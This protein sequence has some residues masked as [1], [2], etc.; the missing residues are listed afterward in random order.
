MGDK[1]KITGIYCIENIIDGKKYIG[2]GKNIIARWRHHRSDLKLNKHGNGYLQNVYNKYGEE[3]LKYWIVQE[4]SKEYLLLMEIYWIAYYN[5]YRDDGGGYNLTRGGESMSNASLETRQK[6]SESQK[7]KIVSEET[8]QRI[9]KSL[10]G[11]FRGENSPNFGKTY[12]RES[13]EKGIKSK[14]GKYLGK[15]NKNYGRK[16]SEETRRK[17]SE[18]H[19]GE[20]SHIFGKHLSEEHK[21]KIGK[22]N[23][24]PS[25]ETRE[26]RSE[27]M[28]GIKRG[29]NPTS[30]YIG[31]YFMDK[32]KRKKWIAHIKYE[33]KSITIGSFYTELEAA[34]AYNEAA[35]YFYG[36]KAKLNII[37]PEQIEELW[38]LEI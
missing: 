32:Y 34:M 19:T 1:I 17:Q 8:R 26:K 10:V 15:N 36:W 33:R 18:S 6:I 5:S 7:G 35:E 29:K 25:I 21:E 23:T 9:S 28:R 12:S 22:A 2:R 4:C 27:K 31:V 37:T 11:R 3:N 14:K 13:V 30:Q 38:N 24:N 16:A 20:K